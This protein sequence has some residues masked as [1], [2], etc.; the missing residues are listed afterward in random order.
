M[1]QLA[2]HACVAALVLRVLLHRTLG[3]VLVL[4]L[5]HK[6]SP[7]EPGI[8]VGVAL[9]PT[10]KKMLG[11]LRKTA[12]QPGRFQK[13]DSPM[14]LEE[15]SECSV[16]NSQ[17]TGKDTV[18]CFFTNKLATLTTRE[19]RLLTEIRCYIAGRNFF[20]V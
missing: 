11:A 2:L 19:L 14:S 5:L 15:C 8:I 3:L 10:S 16:T 20:G 1:P 9:L 7:P 6:V 17:L 12:S 4:R 13:S 18:L